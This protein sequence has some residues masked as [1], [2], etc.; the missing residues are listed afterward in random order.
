MISLCDLF[1]TL[2]LPRAKALLVFEHSIQ[3]LQLFFVIGVT[4]H[5]FYTSSSDA[6]RDQAFTVLGVI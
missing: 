5:S 6:S 2:V 1:G 3:G 4:V